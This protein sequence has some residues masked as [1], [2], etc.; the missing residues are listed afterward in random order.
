MATD[1]KYRHTIGVGGGGPVYNDKLVGNFF[2]HDY[3]SFFFFKYIYTV[4][5][6]SRLFRAEAAIIRGVLRCFILF[7]LHYTP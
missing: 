2:F 5:S 4:S 6:P 3:F 7:L 1:E